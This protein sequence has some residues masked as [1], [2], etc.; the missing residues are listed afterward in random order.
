MVESSG[1]LRDA[2]LRE[3][4]D[5]RY[6][7]VDRLAVLALA[8]GLLACVPVFAPFAIALGIISIRRIRK[9][10]GTLAGLPVAVIGI[11]AAVLMAGGWTIFLVQRHLKHR[12]GET[13]GPKVVAQFFDWM[14]R[15]YLD[16]CFALLTDAGKETYQAA[17]LKGFQEHLVG[18]GGYKAVE[19]TSTWWRRGGYATTAEVAEMRFRVTTGTK[20]LYFSIVLVE[21]GDAWRI[22]Q[23]KPAPEDEAPPQDDAPR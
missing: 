20:D 1:T 16:D 12:R 14:S 2:D 11:A 5:L 9:S 3:G 7:Q 15:G 21:V 10:Q 4:K 8:L 18:L 19:R 6:A 13:E 22:D 23:I 17:Y